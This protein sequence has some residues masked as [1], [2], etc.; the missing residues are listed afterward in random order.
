MVSDRVSPSPVTVYSGSAI[1]TDTPSSATASS[2]WAWASSRKVGAYRCNAWNSFGLSVAIIVST[3]SASTLA[4]NASAASSGLS[5][6]TGAM[7]SLGM[8]TGSLAS[9][10]IVSAM[11]WNRLRYHRPSSST[12]V[13]R[14]SSSSSPS[15]AEPSVSRSERSVSMLSRIRSPIGNSSPST[16]P[17]PLAVMSTLTMSSTLVASAR[18]CSFSS[19]MST[20]ETALRSASSLSTSS[21]WS[22]AV[23]SVTGSRS[24]SRSPGSRTSTIPSTSSFSR[25]VSRARPASSALAAPPLLSSLL[26]RV[27]PKTAPAAI[28]AAPT[29]PAITTPV[30]RFLGAGRAAPTRSP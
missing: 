10:R 2:S 20:P 21:R 14:K 5:P 11:E 12:A 30:D 24:V 23:R 22:S 7:P 25:A 13:S 3:S 26:S 17:V 1:V 6:P 15:S 28:A 29:T 16:L 4:R 8:S 19:T 27:M 9:A 18:A